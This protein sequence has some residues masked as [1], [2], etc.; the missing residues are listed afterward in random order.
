MFQRL[1]IANRGE[2][3]ARVASSARKLGI[4]PYGVVSEADRDSAWARAL[5]G[6]VCLGPAASR[7]SYLRADAVVQAAVQQ[8]CSALHPGWGFLSEDPLFAALC[9]QHGVTFVG[10]SPR[11]MATMGRKAAAKA[12]MRAAGVPVIPGSLGLLASADEAAR[13]AAEVGYPVILKAD[14]GGGGRGMRRCADE[15]ELRRGYA[16]AAQEAAAAFGSGALYLERYLEGGRHVEVQ[17]LGDRYGNAVHLFERDCSV[18]RNHQKLVEESPCPLLSVSERSELGA[19]A[20]RAAREVGYVGAGTI[21][22]LRT[23]EGRIVFMEMNTRLQVEHPVSEL[24]TGLDI[25]AEQL[26]V[27]AGHPLSVA[28][29]DVRLEGHA[30]EVRINAEDPE[31]GFKPSPGR[32]ERFEFALD[33][34]PGRVRVD[35][36][37][38][39]GETVPPHYDSL[40]AKLIAHG[41]DRAEAIATALAALDGV[42]IEGVATTVPLARAILSSREFARG[43]YDTRAI[44]GFAVGAAARA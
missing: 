25:V 30:I 1:L 17:V 24:V 11:V 3:V 40:I 13:T 19:M 44:P 21:E 37:L 31:Q 9:A 7:A 28:Q 15:S 29:E 36:H 5:D 35:T 42:R 8:G 16:E 10:P 26:R 38:A 27:A 4:A 39:A 18:Q 32:L 2:V 14:A 20:A 6:V 23:R 43:D 22:F 12:S 34:G 41:R 33:R